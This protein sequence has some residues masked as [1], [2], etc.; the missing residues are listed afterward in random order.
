MFTDQTLWMAGCVVLA[1]LLAASGLIALHLQRRTRIGRAAVRQ[2]VQAQD[3]ALQE[4]QS[5]VQSAQERLAKQA[6][7]NRQ[8]DQFN[9]QRMERMQRLLADFT[10]QRNAQSKTRPRL[11]QVANEHLKGMQGEQRE[12]AQ[13][14]LKLEI[15]VQAARQHA[16]QWESIQAHLR[17]RQ[18]RPGTTSAA[19]T[20]ALRQANV[21]LM[22]ELKEARQSKRTATTQVT[23]LR[24]QL[25]EM[26]AAIAGMP[27]QRVELIQQAVAQMHANYAQGI[28]QGAAQ[29]AANAQELAEMNAR[30]T[31][32]AREVSF[33]QGGPNA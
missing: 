32:L 11:L 15:D 25:D 12:M 23:A 5:Q 4:L 13:R 29:V 22:A 19:S 21:A 20:H 2:M 28:E 10:K 8:R 14:L 31:R 7:F 26:Q 3:L 6:S 24:G 33:L 16:E 9:S 17:T 1:T 18:A 30:V 27:Q